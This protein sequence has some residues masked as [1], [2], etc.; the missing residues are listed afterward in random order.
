MKKFVFLTFFGIIILKGYSQKITEINFKP[1]F[2]KYGVEGCFV[3]YD[4]EGD[5]YIKYNPGICDSGYIPA[6]TFKIP[7]ALIVLEEGIIKDTSQIIKWDGHEWPIEA[8][9]KDQTLKTSIQVSC[10]WVYVKFAEQIGIEKYYDYIKLFDYGNK[11]LAGPPTRFWLSGK[12][13]I[14]ASQQVD[15]LRKLYNY[16]L[17]VSSKNIDIIKGFIVLEETEKYKFS[18][19]TGGGVISDTE[20]IMWLVGY[21]EKDNRPYFFAMN[22][23]AIDFW[24]TSRIRYDLVKDILKELQ[25]IE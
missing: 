20:N 19:K 18:G 6:S 2:D 17:D 5:K 3:M 16:D 15:F 10:V 24:K 22:F 11:N 13:R 25:L 4:Q 8:W 21:L 1:L 23:I 12:F 9:N 14:S 7:H